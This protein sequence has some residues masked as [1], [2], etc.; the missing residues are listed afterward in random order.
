MEICTT[1]DDIL[2]LSHKQGYTCMY[3]KAELE[4]FPQE[5]LDV[6]Y[7]GIEALEH[8]KPWRRDNKI[9]FSPLKRGRKKKVA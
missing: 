9:K 1:V 2:N 8:R 6:I 5:K 4:T 7:A 3:S